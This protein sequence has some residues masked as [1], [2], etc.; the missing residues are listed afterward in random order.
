MSHRTAKRAIAGQLISTEVQKHIE[1]THL[2]PHITN[3]TWQAETAADLID[4]RIVFRKEQHLVLRMLMQQA[5]NLAILGGRIHCN[6]ARLAPRQ[7]SGSCFGIARTEKD[8]FLLKIL[9]RANT[10]MPPLQKSA[11]DA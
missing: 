8:Q 4:N 3:Y 6:A 1:R 9:G 5:F 2:Q 7:H 11:I 10:D